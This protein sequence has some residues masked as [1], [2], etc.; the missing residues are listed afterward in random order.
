MG[1]YHRENLEDLHE[2]FYDFL[3]SPPQ[4][5]VAEAASKR[6][7]TPSVTKN[8]STP[9][10]NS[11]AV[12]NDEEDEVVEETPSKPPSK[13]RPTSKQRTTVIRMGPPSRIR[14]LKKEMWERRERWA[15]EN[16]AVTEDE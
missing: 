6:Y 10:G 2:A 1:A 8:T 5:P 4:F 16:S 11:F 14:D 12:L 13:Q 7:T 9:I 3:M 15:A